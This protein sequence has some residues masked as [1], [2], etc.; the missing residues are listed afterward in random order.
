VTPLLVKLERDQHP[1]LDGIL[2]RLEDNPMNQQLIEGVQNLLSIAEPRRADT[3]D[4]C[5]R[6]LTTLWGEVGGEPVC[7]GCIRKHAA[8][9]LEHAERTEALEC[10]GR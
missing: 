9:V 2:A 4:Q 6:T 3:C 10:S 1:W 7:Q 8:L 5:E